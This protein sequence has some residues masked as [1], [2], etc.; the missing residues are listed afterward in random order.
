VKLI[1]D[2]LNQE[3]KIKFVDAQKGDVRHTWA[4]IELAKKELG[5]QP[6]VQIENG[7]RKYL[8]SSAINTS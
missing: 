7:L 3:A 6:R 5:W 1:G 2:L 8:A 4:H